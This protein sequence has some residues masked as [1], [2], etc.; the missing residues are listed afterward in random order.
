MSIAMD[1]AVV[2]YL[3][4]SVCS[5][6]VMND[7]IYEAQTLPIILQHNNNIHCSPFSPTAGDEK[8]HFYYTFRSFQ[9][10]LAYFLLEISSLLSSMSPSLVIPSSILPFL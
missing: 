5:I 6:L 7:G 8:R 9:L 4:D 10:F 1:I 3:L 2:E